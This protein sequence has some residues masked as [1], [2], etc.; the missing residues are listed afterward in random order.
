M[1]RRI[2]LFRH[3]KSSWDDRAREDRGRDLSARGRKASEKMGE[4]C[5]A[6]AVVPDLVLCSTATRARE[7]LARL[8]PH[9]KSAARIEFED[10]LY[11]AEADALLGRLRRLNGA[12]SGVMVVG[13]N[14]GPHKLAATLAGSGEPADLARLNAKFPT[15]ALAE[16][17]AD[18]KSWRDLDRGK[19]RLERFILP[20]ELP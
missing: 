18:L 5:A 1:K 2:Y 17:S 9:L 11:L 6:N 15:A 20:R 14:P 4:W 7:T 10:A 3:G 12:A 16:L 19:C 13:H 8:L